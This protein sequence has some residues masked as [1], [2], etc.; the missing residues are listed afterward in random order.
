VGLDV[1]GSG[2]LPQGVWPAPG[3]TWAA[4]ESGLGALRRYLMDQVTAL[5]SAGAAAGGQSHT[6]VQLL[7]LPADTSYT[8]VSPAGLAAGLGSHEIADW[9][10]TLDSRQPRLLLANG[11][12][13][14]GDPGD[15]E[16][17]PG[18]AGA[19][20][21]RVAPARLLPGLRPY[22]LALTDYSY[23]ESDGRLG[24]LATAQ[25]QWLLFGLPLGS[26]EA[27]ANL[28]IELY[29]VVTVDA[30]KARVVGIAETFARG[31]LRQRLELAEVHGFGV[32]VG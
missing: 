11:L 7:E 14:A 10:M 18:D 25:A 23:G 6:A 12:A 22:P 24:A 15:P 13:T 1:T 4:N 28:G 16:G 8:Y 2:T 17:S 32:S 31:R 20:A 27:G 3:F 5:R 26:I 21:W 30:T 9:Q 19:K 29:D